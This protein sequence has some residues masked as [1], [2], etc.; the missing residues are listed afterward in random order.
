M[1]AELHGT[2]LNLLMETDKRKRAEE[3]LDSMQRIWQKFTEQLSLVEPSSLVTE[4]IAAEDGKPAY[5]FVEELCRH[6]HVVRVVSDSISREFAKA[7]AEYEMEAQIE[8]KNFEI[9]RLCDRVHYYEAVNHEMCQRNQETIELARRRRQRRK[10]RQLLV[11]GSIGAAISLG[12][13]AI[14]WSFCLL[15][16]FHLILSTEMSP[17]SNELAVRSRFKTREPNL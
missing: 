11:W 5:N 17:P 14:A 9:A 15:P 4:A 3:S 13:A 7:E 10:R 2:Q 12:T 16:P 8:A 6:I 1:E